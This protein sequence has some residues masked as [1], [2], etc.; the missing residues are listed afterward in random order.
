MKTAEEH[1]RGRPTLP[2]GVTAEQ[3]LTVAKRHGAWNIRVFGSFARGEARPD[4]DFDLLI[5]LEPGRG[6][7]DIV[8]IKQ[9]LEALLGRT[10][11]VLTV[12]ALSRYIRDDVVREAV[13]L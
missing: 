7:F 1:A 11:D 12:N 9:E 6:L 2:Q 4:S 8:D 5:D 10:V 3:I 13:A